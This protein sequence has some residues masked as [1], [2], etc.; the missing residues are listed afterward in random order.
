MIVGLFSDR[1][2]LSCLP[3]CVPNQGSDLAALLHDLGRALCLLLAHAAWP[4]GTHVFLELSNQY[5]ITKTRRWTCEKRN[6]YYMDVYIAC[7]LPVC[8]FL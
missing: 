8:S 1:G 2:C 6:K 7:A 5:P 3:V 4:V